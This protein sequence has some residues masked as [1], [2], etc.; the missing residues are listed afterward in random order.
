MRLKLLTLLILYLHRLSSNHCKMV[1]L[2]NSDGTLVELYDYSSN[3]TYV[4]DVMV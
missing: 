4:N 2:K 1:K 3:G